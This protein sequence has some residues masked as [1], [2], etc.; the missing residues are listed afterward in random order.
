MTVTITI[1]GAN[2]APSAGSD[3]TGSVTEDASTT[4]A[5]GTVSGTDA[6]DSA[7]LTYTPNT[8]SGTYGSIAFSGASWTYTLDNSDADTTALD[9]NDQ[10][11]DTFTVTVSDSV[12]SDTMDIVI[13][14]TGA[15]DAPSWKRPN[16]ISR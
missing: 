14:V 13:T 2:D 10:V 3:Q 8:N 4:T 16:G 11:T 5:T 1:T 7:S 6:D 9:A 15:N 12:A